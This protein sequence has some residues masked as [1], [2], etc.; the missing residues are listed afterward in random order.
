MPIRHYSTIDSVILQLDKAMQILCSPSISSRPY[1]AQNMPESSLTPQEKQHI[2][3]LMRVNHAGE[4]AAQGLYQGQASTAK[5][6]NIQEK[7][8]QCAIE[9]M[10]H[11]AWCEQRL[12]ELNSRPSRLNPF[13][14]VGSYL[15]GKLAGLAGDKWSLGFVEETEHQVMKHL[16]DHLERLP[17]QDLKTTVIIKQ[18][19]VDEA[20]HGH[21]AHTLGAAP[22]P[23]PIQWLMKM[24]SKIMTFTAYR[25]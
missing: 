12:Q 13:W 21:T 20:H 2:A 1:P 22:L 9:E 14:Y 16:D 6:I 19:H 8:E 17:A 11:L 23:R 3:G 7:M 4:I 15:I 24:T 10:D 18:I 5:Q 25:F